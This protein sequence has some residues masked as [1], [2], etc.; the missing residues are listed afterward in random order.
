MGMQRVQGVSLTNHGLVVDDQGL[1]YVADTWN[2]RIQV[3]DK[4]GAFFKD[5]EQF[6]QWTDQLDGFGTAGYRCRP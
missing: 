5:V 6:R 1:V 2:H 3:F 4:D